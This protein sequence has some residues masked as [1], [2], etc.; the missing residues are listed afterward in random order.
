MISERLERSFDPM[1]RY[2]NQS[3]TL[4]SCPPGPPCCIPEAPTGLIPDV[5]TNRKIL[6][7]FCLG[8]GCRYNIPGLCTLAL[9]WCS[10]HLA[11]TLF[12]SDPFALNVSV[13]D[14]LERSVA[15]DLSEF[16]LF[17]NGTGFLSP[18]DFFPFMSS[19]QPT[20]KTPL[21]ISPFSSIILAHVY[22]V[23]GPKK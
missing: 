20:T 6:C 19:T 18:G 9:S 14:P 10:C 3:Y 12:P 15:S 16:T 4:L 23:F 1:A 21:Y 11:K 22:A 7:S 2:G 13:A 17:P 5:V 8:Q